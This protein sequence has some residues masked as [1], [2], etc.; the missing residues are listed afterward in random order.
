MYNKK[1]WGGNLDPA[2]TVKFSPHHDDDHVVSL[3][4]FEFRDE[5]FLGRYPSE[6]SFDVCSSCACALLILFPGPSSLGSIGIGIAGSL[7]V[8]SSLRKNTFATT[9]M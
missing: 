9:K 2:I 1:A 6:D 4:I 3:I 8:T 7:R 5:G